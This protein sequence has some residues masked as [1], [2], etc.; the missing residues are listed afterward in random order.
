MKTYR[1]LFFDLDDTLWDFRSNSREVL[2]ELCSEMLKGPWGVDQGEFIRTY[3]EVNAALWRQLDGGIIPKEVLRALR[4][5]KTLEGLGIHDGPLAREMEE[6]YMERTPRRDKLMPGALSLLQDLRPHYRLHIITNGFSDTQYTKLQ[7]S[8]IRGFF[9]VVLTSEM[10]GASKPSGR[11]FRHALRS[12]GAK[13]A[14]SLMIGD[15]ALA[16]VAGGRNAGLDQAHFVPEGD[17]D[18]EAT[19][20]I[21]RLDELRAILLEVPPQGLQ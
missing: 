6:Q 3:E 7:A 17:G 21:H 16:D 20:R 1:H 4:F 12:A 18:P 2:G 13:A 15:S 14:T 8:G 11:I 5:R 19:Y 9:D 10:A